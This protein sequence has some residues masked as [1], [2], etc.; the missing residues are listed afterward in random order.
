MQQD[1]TRGIVETQLLAWS[2]H[3]E[4]LK[5]K[6]ERQHAEVKREYYES[7]EELREDIEAQLKKWG[8]EIEAPE[9]TELRR[10]IEADLTASEADIETLKGWA[11]QAETEAKGRIDE[12]KARR[13]MLK[14][15]MSELKHTSGGSWEDMKT[16]AIKAWDELRPALHSAVAK[17]R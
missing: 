6:V 14:D 9:Y 8:K 5:A 2:T 12:L 15:K 11:G 4:R 17:F 1:E 3:V 10:A 7:L 13:R 16:G